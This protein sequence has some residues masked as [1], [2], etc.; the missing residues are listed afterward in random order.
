MILSGLISI[1]F[2]G[3]LLTR[4][5]FIP[6]FLAPLTSNPIVSP[7]K[8]ASEAFTFKAFNAFSKISGL[9]LRLLISA[10]MTM[11]LKN[12]SSRIFRGV[13]RRIQIGQS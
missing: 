10:L 13:S 8:T 2:I 7:I 6:A 3:L 5:D 12:F 9:G 1:S 4:T 11:T